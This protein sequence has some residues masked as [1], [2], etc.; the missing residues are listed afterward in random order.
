MNGQ[1]L[2]N[3]MMSPF[4]ASCVVFVLILAAALSIFV[5]PVLALAPLVAGVLLWAIFR[6]P[7][8]ALGA[9]LA[10]MPFDFMAIALGK[11]FGL[12]HMTLVSV[13]SKEVPLLL[14]MALLWRR[15]GFKPTAPDWWLL[16][17]LLLACVRTLLDGSLVALWT[18]F[19]FV[20]PYFV[21]RMAVLTQ[22]QEHLW[23]RCAVWIV[24]V[25]SMLGLLEVFVFGEGP[26]TLLYLV[27]DTGGTEDGVLIASFHG[28]G[29]TGLR[30]AATMVGPN[31]F[32]AL[33]MIALI[34]WW[35][36][37]RNPLPA[38]MVATG[39][40]CSVTRADWLGTA[41][42]I[43]LLAVIMGQRKRFFL[44]AT[45]ALAMFVASIPVLGLS[46]YLFF[47]K[48]G[49]DP[50]AEYHQEGIVN[51]LKYA[52]DHPFGVSN[53]NLSPATTTRDSKGTFFETTYP[54]FAA[55]YGAA[56]ALSF[57]GFLLR[58]LRFVWRKQGRLGFAAVGILV[59]IGVVMIFT[60][61]LTDRRLASWAF[62][63]VGLAIRSCLNGSNSG[64]GGRREVSEVGAA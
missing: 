62:F 38:G 1:V 22:A 6:H 60:L 3:P 63:P 49:E 56:V 4:R 37:C 25:L 8:A 59:G 32:G 23:A 42:A 33:C 14:L 31:S 35:V 55:A 50:S 30:E 44:Y 58:A 28:Q 5:S 9:V 20:V 10:F 24:A 52:A 61:P 47:A 64:E 2:E 39:L 18:D 48:T 53:A 43:P 11:F 40:I 41:A 57:V 27:L 13:C 7:T 46:D 45:L 26:R 29:F 19:S 36:Y 15:N 51:G 12:P 16:G 54:Y 17:C 34:L 21:G